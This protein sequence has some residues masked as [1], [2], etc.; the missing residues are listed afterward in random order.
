MLE[1][2]KNVICLVIG[3]LFMLSIQDAFPSTK[4]DGKKHVNHA[5]ETM[6]R[7][8]VQSCRAACSPQCAKEPK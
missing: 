7:A 5:E 1:F 3:M 4:W 6:T 8:C 2:I